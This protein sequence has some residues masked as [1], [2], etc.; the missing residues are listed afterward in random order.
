M[1]SMLAPRTEDCGFEPWSGH[2]ND[3]TLVFVASLLSMQHG[4]VRTK[5]G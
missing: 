3:I 4:G 5:T 1:V 2:T